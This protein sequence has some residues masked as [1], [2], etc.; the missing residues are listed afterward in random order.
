MIID[1]HGHYT[2]AP[3][4]LR[5]YRANQIGNLGR[6]TKGSVNISDEQ[7]RASL[8]NSQVKQ[9]RERGTDLTIFS[10]QASAM[11]HHFGSELVSRYWTEVNNEL[12]HRVCQLFPD[13]FVG[14]CQ[15]PQS[16][17][18]S[19]GN[20]IEELRRCILDFGFV[21]CNVNPDPSGGVGLTPSL[22]DE[23]WYPLYEAL[24]ALDVPA[25]IHV[26]ASVNPALHTT[27]AYYINSDTAA[28]L[29]LLESRVF[30]DF[31]TLKIV[32]PHGGGAVPYQ[33]ARYRGIN[34][35]AGREPFEEAIKKLYFDTAIYSQDAVETL[36][37]VV[38]VDHVLFA[39]EM[40][41]AVNTIDPAT[42]RWFDD[43]KPY[44]DG[45]AWLTDAD[46]QKLFEDN[47]RRVYSRLP[48]QAGAG[49]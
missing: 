19:P 41:G 5:A 26:S 10:P 45:I 3:A 7:I 32:I 4:A 21:G 47:A 29:Q 37:K 14:V 46:R 36:I 13:Q 28:V 31:P 18:V 44:V 24:V 12:I 9:Q 23:W 34:A 2:T 25:M 42:G 16:P 6:P 30:D 35:V 15:L 33:L 40:V 22:G 20:S 27:A 38:G 8:E 43:T 49:R 1:I 17:G 48:S 39:S 11:G